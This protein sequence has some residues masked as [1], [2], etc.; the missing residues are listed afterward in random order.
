MVEWKN[1]SF[2]IDGEPTRIF[3]GAIHYFRSFKQQWYDLLLKLK[4]A[5]L[6]TVET[7]C[8]WNLHE[9]K[10]GEFCFEGNLDIDY[11]IKTAQELGL[12]VI[13]RPG[14]YICAEWEYGGLP[15]WLL[16]ED[17]IRVRTTDERYISA[18]KSYFDELMPR[19]VPHLQTNGGNVI[20]VA[21]E[22][23]YGSFGNSREYMNLCAAMLKDYG[24][25][26]PLFTADGHSPLFI[27][28][29]Q[30]DNHLIALDFGYDRSM[31]KSHFDEQQRRQPDSPMFH[32]EHWIGMFAHWGEG[33][34]NYDTE[35]VA[36]EV[37][38]HLEE[39]VDFNLY[40]FHGGTNYGF[41]NG[42]ND[43]V[44]T[45]GERERVGY[46]PDITSYDY[47]A[48][49]NEWGECT[50]KYFAI[51]R[52]MEKYYG[53]ELPKPEPIELQSLGEVECN[54]C[55]GLFD[56][57]D[58]IG[59]KHHSCTPL[60]ME[61]FGQCFGY[62]L[63]R[64][65]INT[66][67]K[68][69]K[70]VFGSF[71]DRLHVYF[72]GVYI[73]TLYRNDARRHVEIGDWFKKGGRLDILVENLGRINFG[74]EMCVGDRK[75]ILDYVYITY[76]WGPRQLLNEWD[77][78]TLPME[79]LERIDYCGVNK[80]QPAF[81]R[82]HFK[83]E[84]KKDCFVHL[85]GFKKGFVVVNGF[86]LGRFWDIGPQLSLYLPWPLLRDD[87]EIIVFSEEPS[88]RPVISIRDYH[89]IDSVKAT[90]GP[91]TIV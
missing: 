47:D 60:S 57:L 9:P 55:A 13:V 65:V 31:P 53:Y 77:I 45:D 63:Y 80:G 41:T 5:G 49:L 88:D 11:F 69:E 76:K 26:V 16:G 54:E 50:E 89:I 37:R 67:V 19:I 79:N 30:T 2:Y 10:R 27:D 7:Y 48:P 74:P 71:A 22:N 12:Y 46:A 84:K 75:G 33:Y 86:N 17:G 58:A 21:A 44:I 6:N 35:T 36:N 66:D 90:E 23:E 4:N 28:G 24:V 85:D 3:S 34:I 38:G 61:H 51:Q 68:P 70:L 25:D 64:H 42:A 40:M 87:N 81:Y 14:P 8:C 32:V 59:T 15:G 72:D 1:K 39:N 29:G 62:I 78:F 91:E 73:D 18:L 52:E 43:F 56:N 20:L 83:A 82:G